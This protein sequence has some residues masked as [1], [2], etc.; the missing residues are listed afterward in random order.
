[1]AEMFFNASFIL[2]SMRT[3][4]QKWGNDN[5][6]RLPK[7]ILGPAGI[8]ENDEV[9]ITAG[10]N[11]IIIRKAVKHRTFSERMEGYKGKYVAEEFDP[12]SFGNERF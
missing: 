9:V 12:S 7:S 3:F 8:G 10:K 11:E 4:I 5:A 6:V 2:F 1:M